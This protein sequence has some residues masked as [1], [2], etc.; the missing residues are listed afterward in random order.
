[1]LVRKVVVFA[2]VVAAAV[3][4]AGPT[5]AQGPGSDSCVTQSLNG[6]WSNWEVTVV[7]GPCPVDCATNL[8]GQSIECNSGLDC[9]GIVYEISTAG[10]SYRVDKAAID[11][12]G[13]TGLAVSRRGGGKGVVILARGPIPSGF[14]G[15]GITVYPPCAGFTE[16]LK[17]GEGS[18]HEQAI[19]YSPPEGNPDGFRFSVV[20]EGARDIATTAI[21]IKK[22]KKEYCEILGFGRRIPD[23]CVP[24]CGNFNVNQTITKTEILNFKGCFVQFDFDLNTGEVLGVY[25]VEPPEDYEGGVDPDDC[26]LVPFDIGELTLEIPNSTVPMGGT[27]GDGFISA[28]TD[29]CSCRVIGGRVYCWGRNCPQ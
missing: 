26:D 5:A 18:C 2:F 9:T 11:D 16:F 20:V 25:K 12:S 14:G 15:N 21:G 29:S 24:G 27:F 28:G 17:L 8:D 4:A 3:L 6:K 23:S 10:K 22:S 19:L 13:E 1:M 7:E